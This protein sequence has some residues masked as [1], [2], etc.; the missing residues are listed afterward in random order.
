[1]RSRLAKCTAS[2]VVSAF[3][4]LLFCAT[5]AAAQS[6][7]DRIQNFA[8]DS[9]LWVSASYDRA[10]ALMLGLALFLS[11]PLLV[12]AGA[13][14]INRS[15][16]ERNA[17]VKHIRK[18]QAWK[19]ESPYDDP[20][21]TEPEPVWPSRAWIE[22]EV[23]PGRPG[24]R[25]RI[26]PPLIR[27]GRDAENDVCLRHNSVDRFHAAIYR[28]DDSEFFIRDLTGEAGL[29]VWVNGRRTGEAR[30]EP[31]D[32]IVLGAQKITFHAEPA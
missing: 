28:N 18:A 17:S 24:L 20:L 4:T 16:A 21:P 6:F 22:F 30:L 29:G 12:L 3:C 14:L 31:G 13:V 2:T 19:L 1:M 32:A 5:P 26:G 10:P 11:M 27:I 8:F 9:A 7:S 15:R 25:H 23:A